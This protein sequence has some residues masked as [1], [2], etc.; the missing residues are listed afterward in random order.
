MNLSCRYRPKPYPGD[1]VLISAQDL[2]MQENIIKWR[3][4]ISGKLY[5]HEVP[6]Y[7]ERI[8]DE[9]EVKTIAQIINKHLLKD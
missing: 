5:T 3:N 6:G 4:N 9:L 8:M 1:I 2:L 7:H